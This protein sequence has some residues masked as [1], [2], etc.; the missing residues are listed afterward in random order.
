MLFIILKVHG[1][2]IEKYL[3]RINFVKFD[4]NS[5]CT[6]NA[7]SFLFTSD[8]VECY[9]WGEGCHLFYLISPPYG[10]LSLNNLRTTK[11]TRFIFVLSYDWSLIR[12]NTTTSLIDFESSIRDYK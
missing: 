1:I 6:R 11:F 4:F 3:L 2:S 12:K 8:N 5:N 7:A 10:K 9:P